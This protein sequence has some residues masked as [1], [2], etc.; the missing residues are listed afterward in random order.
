MVGERTFGEPIDLLACPGIGPVWGIASADLNATLLVWPA[1]EHIAE[2]RNDERD[3]LLVV[4]EGSM[5]VIVDD[6]PHELSPACALLIDSGRRRS[7]VVGADGVR[8]LSIHL[9]RGPLQIEPR[10]SSD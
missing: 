8:H 1:G 3:V 9:R 2:H 6:D 4:I 10:P 7:F 5:T